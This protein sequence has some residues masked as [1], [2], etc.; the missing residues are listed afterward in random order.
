MSASS[1]FIFLRA[2]PK[3]FRDTSGS[4][5]LTWALSKT[6]SHPWSKDSQVQSFVA[7]LRTTTLQSPVPGE[8]VF[9]AIPRVPHLAIWLWD[10]LTWSFWS[11]RIG[12]RPLLDF[13]IKYWARQR[14]LSPANKG[15]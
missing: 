12:L 9:V 1:S 7:P 11:R 6:G 2:P 8:I 10:F 5:C 15:L 14:Q 3:S 13:M 4:L